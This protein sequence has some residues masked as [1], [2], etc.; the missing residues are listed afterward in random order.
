MKPVR[1]I[2][3]HPLDILKFAKSAIDNGHRCVLAIIAHIEGPSARAVGTMMAIS[4]TG[5]Y[6]GCVSN[7][8]VDADIAN[9]ALRVLDGDEKNRRVRY[10]AGS[11]YLDI[12]LP[13]G[14]AVEIEFIAEP[15]VDVVSE[16]IDRFEQR[17]P[18]SLSI[19]NSGKIN[20]T[21]TDHAENPKCLMLSYA[22]PLQ[23]AIAGRGEEVIAL[24]RLARAAR[25]DVTVHS[26]DEDVLEVCAALGAQTTLLTSI[27][28]VPVFPDDPWSAIVCL[29]HDHE[30]ESDL[31]TSALNTRAYY[32]GAMGSPRT[33]A[34][35]LQELQNRGID[36]DSL[37]RIRGP[38]GLIPSV[39]DA[40]KLAISA[41]AEIVD[42]Y[43]THPK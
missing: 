3:E 38:I 40:S 5:Q 17:Q 16:I 29:F 12:R 14:G 10:G 41:L 7:G 25:Y 32:I 18:V 8:C 34:N 26:P 20:I 24:S 9:H 22:P 39:R 36:D 23:I 19:E 1:N 35:R 30:W 13:C 37:K 42:L 21:R 27:S 31:L 11:P 33:H 28:S 43:R 15:D 2:S 6:A 4:N